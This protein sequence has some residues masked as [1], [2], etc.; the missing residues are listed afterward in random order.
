MKTAKT[1]MRKMSRQCEY[2]TASKAMLRVHTRTAHK[3]TET[4]KVNSD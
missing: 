1:K 3:E 4:H 2:T